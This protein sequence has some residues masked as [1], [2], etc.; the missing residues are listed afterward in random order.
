MIRDFKRAIAHLRCSMPLV[1][2]SALLCPA[3]VC[4]AAPIGPV[5]PD[6]DASLV[7]EPAPAASQGEA[8][9]V[10]TPATDPFPQDDVWIPPASEQLPLGLVSIDTE[11]AT[12]EAGHET[13]S[14]PAGTLRTVLALAGVLL[15][16]LS[17]AW[18][19]KKVARLSGGI[20]GQVGAGGR[21]PAGL[22]EVLARYPMG[23]RQTLVVLRFDRRVLLCSVAGGGRS[24][25]GSMT[26]LCELEDPEDIA[27]VLVKARDESGDSIARTFERA[28][29]EESDRFADR[30]TSPDPIKIRVPA[31]YAQSQYEAA[32]GTK[33][34]TVESLLR[35]RGAS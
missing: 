24:G 15:L 5:V 3:V 19:F 20:A 9:L 14:L 21:A 11:A 18:G 17:L 35:G 6:R 1:F 30:Q 13:A 4:V 16:I 8:G 29:E 22:V 33:P 32:G 31:G 34:R 10:A 7:I 27:S 26:T 23:G 2:I 25:G 12:S 28:M